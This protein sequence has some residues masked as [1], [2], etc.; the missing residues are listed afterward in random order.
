MTTLTD[1]ATFDLLV[2]GG[3]SAGCAAAEGLSRD[4]R[5]SVCLIEAGGTNDIFRVKTPGMM[6]FLPES[7][8]WRFETVPQVGLNGR[9]GYQPRGRGLGGSSAINAMIYIRGHAWDYDHWA[10]LG[11]SGWSYADVL[12]VFRA[13]EDNV[14]GADDFHG[15]GGP[16]SVSDQGW[17]NPGSH[18]F[19]EAAARLQLP[20]N[21]DFN[22]AVQD[23]F[24]LYQTTMR[25]GERWSASRAFIEPNRGRANITVQTGALIERL[26]VAEGR[27]TGA[28]VRV[29]GQRRKK[30]SAVVEMSR[31]SSCKP[32]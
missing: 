9:R 22:G 26:T 21:D 31:S 12:P 1:G 29:G 7:T 24:G 10:E 18:I 11:C 5:H 15:A 23:G 17:A 25:G 19:V 6:P 8:N 2:L 14:R 27:V 32:P 4:G 13:M 30:S 16:L 20:I 3:G 28:I